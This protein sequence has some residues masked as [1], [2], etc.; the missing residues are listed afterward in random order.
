MIDDH[1]GRTAGRA[2][3]L[4]RAVDEILGTHTAPPPGPVRGQVRG[5]HLPLGIGQVTGIA[6]GPPSGLAR[7][8]GT[9][10]FRVFLVVTHRDHGPAAGIR[11]ARHTA[12][13]ARPVPPGRRLGAGVQHRQARVGQDLAHAPSAECA[14][15]G[16]GQQCA[17]LDGRTGSSPASHLMTLRHKVL[18]LRPLTLR[19]KAEST[20]LHRVDEGRHREPH[21]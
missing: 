17:D 20:L 11:P 7:T 5:H 19:Y 8:L 12:T 2:T 15:A 16:P 13:P 21:I 9:R 3:M 10:G 18:G 6:P 1:H 14:P 4:V